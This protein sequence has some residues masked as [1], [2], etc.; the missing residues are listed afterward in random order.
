MARGWFG[1][2][3]RHSLASRGIKTKEVRLSPKFEFALFK[4]K[5]VTEQR[6]EEL[7]KEISIKARIKFMG[8]A[9]L[10][11]DRIIEKKKKVQE[12]ST[13]IKRRKRIRFDSIRHIMESEKLQKQ[14]HNLIGTIRADMQELG[15]IEE[16]L[17][18]FEW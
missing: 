1:E 10:L 13:E 12:L 18:R 5:S 14:K 4:A 11:E 9:E 8:R 2:S 7:Q 17:R 6:K 16:I 3:R 15:R